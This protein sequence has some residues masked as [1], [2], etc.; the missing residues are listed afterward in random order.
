MAARATPRKRSLSQLIRNPYGRVAKPTFPTNGPYVAWWIENHCVHVDGVL[1]GQP[2][3]LDTYQ[4]WVLNEMF[5]VDP[6]TG[7][8]WWREFALLVPRGSDKSGL[9][10]ALGFYFLVE[11]GEG[12]PEIYSTAW[13]T[14]QAG[15]VFDPAKIMHDMSPAL[16]R[17][18]L[19]FTGA[20]TAGSGTWK[21]LSRIAETKQGKKPSIL[22]ND[23]YHV[24]KSHE[25]RDA[26]VRGMSK[27]LQPLA[28]DITTE[29]KTRYSPLGRL[30]HGYYDAV[31]KGRGTHE[32]VHPY[33]H[34]YKTGRS[35]MIRWGP[36]WGTKDVDYENPTVV[37][38]CNPASWVDPKRLLEEQLYLPGKLAEDF[39]TYHCNELVEDTGGEGV[40]AD[41]WAACASDLRLQPGQEVVMGIDGGYRR[42]CSA[43]VLTGF[44]G[45]R[46]VTEHHIFRPPRDEGLELDI[47]GTVGVC[48]EQLFEKYQVKRIVG[49]PSLLVT[50][51]QRWM[52]RGLPVREYRH[53]WGDI[54]PDSVRTLEVIQAGRIAHDDDAEF[55]R[56]VLNMRVKYGPNAAWKFADHPDKHRPDSDVPNDAG[57]ALVMSVGEL[58]G[59]ETT[60]L[61][62]SR[63]LLIV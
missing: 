29:G 3:V 37:R 5:R 8:R 55:A 28:V 63:G 20:F 62:G 13:G 52:S 60:G 6:A 24:H 16:Q 10:S 51:F 47:E 45:D 2:K 21:V 12:A 41:M 50:L 15:A 56:H 23:E 46:I 33:L 53:A 40:P 31:E 39:R 30:E 27:R 26:I 43:I 17:L 44:V 25:M 11:D 54:G 7:L 1:L 14:E 57:V 9:A 18:C 49:D 59:D 36:P 22:L 42:D 48:A 61:Y 19:Q 4:R 34:I 58:L 32:E 38:A 35:C